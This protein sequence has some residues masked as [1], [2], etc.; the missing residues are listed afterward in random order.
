LYFAGYFYFY[1][2]GS[3][4]GALKTLPFDFDSVDDEDDDDDDNMTHK[5]MCCGYCMMTKKLG[6]ISLWM[7]R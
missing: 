2:F 6:F 7:M 4:W 1:F 3:F 5:G